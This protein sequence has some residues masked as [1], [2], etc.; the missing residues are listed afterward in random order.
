MSAA[1]HWDPRFDLNG[2]PRVDV[3]AHRLDA[4]WVKAVDPALKPAAADAPRVV[5]AVHPL[6]RPQTLFETAA[7]GR[8]PVADPVETLLDLHEMGLTAQSAE[9]VERLE[10]K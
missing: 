8:L 3:V 5:L 6:R 9:L 2:T 7:R 4:A 1:R 10:R